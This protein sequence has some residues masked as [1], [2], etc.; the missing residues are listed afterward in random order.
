MV[1]SLGGL[2][3]GGRETGPSRE[4]EMTP[5][6]NELVQRVVEQL[7]DQLKGKDR[8]VI[9]K[10]LFTVAL[11]SLV[12]GTEEKFVIELLN[13]KLAKLN[14]KLGLGLTFEGAPEVSEP[15]SELELA[16][17][18]SENERELLKAVIANPDNTI[19]IRRYAEAVAKS[20][21]D[22]SGKG[23]VDIQDAVVETVKNHPE[24]LPKADDT[25]GLNRYI[26]QTRQQ[27]GL[28]VS[29]EEAA[30]A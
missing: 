23:L 22:V 26:N 14:D 27:I 24:Y 21:G 30:A 28:K 19:A 4:A 25:A 5:K 15:A 29:K 11:G 7:G 8:E 1:F 10:E 17:E 2:F 12:H 16:G 20:L 6:A 9:T 18:I 3:G 13:D